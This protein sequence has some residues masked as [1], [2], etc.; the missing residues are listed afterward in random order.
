MPIYKEITTRNNKLRNSI[1]QQGNQDVNEDDEEE[2]EEE[3]DDDEEIEENENENDARVSR[4][5]AR[6]RSAHDTAAAGTEPTTSARLTASGGGVSNRFNLRT[7]VSNLDDTQRYL[8]VSMQH[9]TERLWWRKVCKR[10]VS[11]ILKH[12]DSQ[13]FRQPVSFEDYPD[14]QTVI[15][16]PMDFGTIKTNTCNWHRKR[17]FYH[18]RI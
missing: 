1:G 18:H 7:R 4:W 17:I 9:T 12:P 8:N 13:P 3:E 11:D 15:T 2:E 5:P 6:R 14:Y 16:T 10:L